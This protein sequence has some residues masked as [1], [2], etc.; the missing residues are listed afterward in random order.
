MCNLFDS[1]IDGYIEGRELLKH[2]P[3][4]DPIHKIFTELDD[5][6][7]GKITTKDCLV[8]VRTIGF[9]FSL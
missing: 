7:D 5:D 9:R 2:F 8:I 1:N 6:K 4:H 3:Y